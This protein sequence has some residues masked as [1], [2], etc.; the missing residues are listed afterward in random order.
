M[1]I[2]VN[3]INGIFSWFLDVWQR[4][5]ARTAVKCHFE[6]ITGSQARELL[7]KQFPNA[8]I[9][10]SDGILKAPR[11]A[12]FKAWLEKDSLSTMIWIEDI[13]DCDNF[14]LESKCR[15]SNILAGN[16]SYGFAWFSI[17]AHAI[18]IL[19]SCDDGIFT[20]RQIEPQR[21]DQVALLNENCYLIV[22]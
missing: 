22:M 10:I 16:I 15:A 4:A 3:G 21:D 1:G 18:T 7:A 5:N 6:E 11:W 13:W 20:I 2:N 12:D 8:A 14:A 17:P 19:I 9:H